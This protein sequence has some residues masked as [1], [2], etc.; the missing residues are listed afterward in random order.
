MQNPSQKQSNLLRIWYKFTMII[1]CPNCSRNF[2]LN[3]TLIS[4]N[5]RLLQC[6]VCEHK[7]LFKKNEIIL[8]N[9]DKEKLTMYSTPQIEELT[10]DY[11]TIKN[12]II[13]K[14]EIKD[15]ISE[16]TKV[17]TNSENNKEIKENNLK[18]SQSLYFF[19]IFIVI[20]ISFV[21]IIILL[22]TF[23]V[24]LTKFFPDLNN[25]LNS[26][27]ESLKDIKLFLFDLI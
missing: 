17:H 20:I 13:S 21:A 9:K 11:N 4:D 8:K 22:D 2:E 23:K 27:Y 1:T 18:K 6:G 26:L 24:Y 3:D 15:A 16:D 14:N 5:G 19:N 25:F 10:E 12:E 7:W